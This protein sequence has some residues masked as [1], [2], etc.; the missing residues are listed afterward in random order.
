MEN[1]MQ[2]NTPLIQAD[3]KGKVIFITGAARGLGAYYAELFARNNATVVVSGRSRS[4]D[5]INKVVQKITEAGGKAIPLTLEM[6]DFDSFDRKIE[7]I[8][9][10]LGHID[11]LVNNAA[12]SADKSFFDISKEDWDSHM[13]TN[14]K[15]LF[16]LSQS[17]A[18]Q[19]RKQ[20]SGGNIINI[21]AINGEKIRKNCIPFG[22]SKAAVIHLTK[23]MAYELIEHKI[24]VN[25]VVLGLF[26][27]E[28]VEEWIQKDPGAQDYIA[29]IP[30]K[31]AG[32]FTDLD[33]VVSI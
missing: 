30:A 6:T 5:G 23:S 19:M 14:V 3:L 20:N 22:T 12:V 32:K 31:R 17:V 21:A 1:F 18:R 27:S 26:P 7:E 28:L 2:N 13:E 15:G 11:V 25:A 33:E 9:Q 29:G 4:E 10:K 8:T 16:F 24:R